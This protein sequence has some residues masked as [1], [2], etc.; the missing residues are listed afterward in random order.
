MNA[1]PTPLRTNRDL[2]L[3]IAEL[4]ASPAAGSRDLE[5]HLAALWRL[6]A[7]LPRSAPLALGRF[8]QLLEEAFSTPVPAARPERR[9]RAAALASFERWE[10]VIAA[11]VA[12]LR[13]LR[14]AGAFQNELRYFGLDAPSGARWY[15]F[16]PGAFLECGAQGAFGGSSTSQRGIRCTALRNR[17]SSSATS[18]PRSAPSA[19]SMGSASSSRAS[20]A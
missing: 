16:D 11:Q 3:H 1:P 14:T 10:R 12:D 13:E 5:Q 19:L 18:T 4:A 2:Y 7:G 15:N 6:G 20:T 17:R 9:E 8:A